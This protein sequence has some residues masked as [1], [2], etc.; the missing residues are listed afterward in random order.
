MDEEL[1]YKTID[2]IF[3]HENIWSNNQF[4]DPAKIYYHIHKE[5]EW[6]PFIKNPNI[7]NVNDT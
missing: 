1:P 7:P 3:N 2:F 5:K 4:K 6:L